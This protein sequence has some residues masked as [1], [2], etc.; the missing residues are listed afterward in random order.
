MNFL[1]YP[2][3]MEDDYM[4]PAAVTTSYPLKSGLADSRKRHTLW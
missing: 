1:L 4:L 3:A 2:D